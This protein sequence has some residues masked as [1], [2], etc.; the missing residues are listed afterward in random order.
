MT[1]A[2]VLLSGGLDSVV[3][4]AVLKQKYSE[5]LALTFD[6]GQKSVSSE[7]KA[8]KEISNYYDIKNQIIKL[9]WLGKISNSALNNKTSV[10]VLN[11]NELDN[12]N[13]SKYTM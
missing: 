10:P 9:D 8:V 3:S 5:F 1:N 2:V 11:E 6:Y 4:L 12:I 7:I 13:I